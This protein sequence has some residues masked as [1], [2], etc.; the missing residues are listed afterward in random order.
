MSDTTELATAP[1]PGSFAANL[2]ANKA[3]VARLPE[4][5]HEAALGLERP[6]TAA[7]VD[8]IS[9][10]TPEWQEKVAGLV[11]KMRP[12][13]QGVHMKGSG[14]KI[15]EIKLYHG[16]GNDE[17]RPPK[18]APGDFYTSDSRGLDSEFVA[19]VIGLHETRTMWPPLG[20]EKS[21]PL[22]YSLD[23]AQGSK[24]GKCE[25]CPN[26][27][28][29]PRD[30]GCGTEVVAYLVDKNMTGVY[31]IKFSKTS[32]RAGRN[33][34]NLVQS[35]DE[36]WS[37]W[38]SFSSQ[39]FKES[40]KRWFGIKPTGVESKNP[41]DVYLPK[42]L[43]PVLRAL[44]QAVDAEVYFPALADLYDRVKT[45]SPAI[46]GDTFNEPLADDSAVPDYSNS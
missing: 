14:F 36:I 2:A 33:L 9:K 19:T 1:A 20:A 5:H 6:T 42:E 22:C 34:I 39:E 45:T 7:M 24:Y 37:R 3:L 26:A 15:P 17:S 29:L 35:G 32:Y 40:S 27:K 11:R 46:L 12:N 23:M 10:L 8:I 38:I 44:S 30:G 31:S 25:E 28:K 43:D 16:V 18:L 13:K 4:R 41:A 21:G